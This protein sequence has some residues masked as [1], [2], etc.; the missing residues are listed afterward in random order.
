MIGSAHTAFTYAVGVRPQT[1]VWWGE[2]Q[3][4]P[5]PPKHRT[6]PA[7]HARGARYRRISRSA[8]SNLARALP[9]QSYRTVTWREGTNAPL[10]S[11]FARVRVRAAHGD[12]AACRRMAAH[13]M[14]AK[15]KPSP[16]TTSCAHLPADDLARRL[17]GHR[18]DA[19]AHR[20]RLPRA[21]AGA[22]PRAL[23]GTQLARLSSSC[24]SVYRRLR[25]SDARTALGR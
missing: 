1:T 19:L 6:G 14:A 20:A 23:R 21:Q 4:A 22:R 8:C 18:Q 2:H 9:A 17:G 11:R 7:A 5:T 16:P 12:R 3:P 24:E 10:T 15:A 25:L 13:R